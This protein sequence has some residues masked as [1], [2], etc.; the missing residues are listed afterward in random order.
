MGFDRIVVV[1]EPDSS[2]QKFRKLVA[3]RLAEIGYTGRVETLH[4]S[5]SGYKDPSALYMSDPST[6]GEKFA[7]LLS[8]TETNAQNGDA[9]PRTSGIYRETESGLVRMQETRAGQIIDY[10]LTNFLAR[11]VSNVDRD[12]GAEKS[13]AFEI[14]ARL[15]GRSERLTIPTSRF[16]AMRWPAENL[17]AEAVVYAGHGTTDHARV[18]IQ[19]LSGRPVRRTI[20]THTGWRE[21]ND[22]WMYL[23]GGGAI[24]AKD[25]V[26]SISV[27]LPPELASFR[28]QSPSSPEET[29]TAIRAS[30]RL[31]DLAP[32]QITVPIYGTI[33]RA[34]IGEPDYSTFLFGPTGAFKTEFSA[35]I[36]QHFGPGF[37]SRHLP[38]GFTSTANTNERLAFIAKDAVLVV[39]EFHPP[40]SGGEREHM[41]RDAARLLRSQGNVAG[42]GRMRPDGTLRPSNPPRGLILATGEDLP[43]GQSLHAR[44]FTTEVRTGLV[45]PEKLTACQAD[46]ASCLY[47]QATAAFIRWMAPL[48]TEVRKEFENLRREARRQFHHSHARVSDV[49]AQLTAA[50]SIFVRFLLDVQAIEDSQA[51]E[52]QSR[53]GVALAQAA[54]AQA[55]FSAVS[56]P[57]GR[58][59]ALL[60]SAIAVGRAHLAT[61]NGGAPEHR[62]SACGWR[63]CIIGAGQYE[64]DEWQPQGARVGWADENYIFLDRDAAYRAAQG[65]AIDGGGVEVSPSTLLRRLRDRGL[66]ARVDNPRETLTVRQTVEGRRQDVICISWHSLFPPEPDQPDQSQGNGRVSG[67]VTGRENEGPQTIRP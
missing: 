18:A 65:M 64:R 37:D 36:Q 6:F 67:R 52:L 22:E 19:L 17:G 46:A 2:G 45:D 30:L 39:D 15:N 11:I 43:R 8:E 14:E 59:I 1:S 40:A 41:Q 7:A 58:F 62:E 4:M 34:V 57:V 55:Q 66:L 42:R 38:T 5:L 61:R 47:A 12:D 16:A 50:Y 25:S 3:A 9:A 27:E 33:W 28:L 49:R 13:H 20:Y 51:K 63:K 29:I 44:V 48:R 23:H 26:A 21:I 53:L 31:L 35:L 60:T 56:E 10:P 24:G 54:T 32:D